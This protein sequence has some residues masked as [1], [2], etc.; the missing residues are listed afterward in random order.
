MWNSCPPLPPFFFPFEK[1]S[2]EPM[3]PFVITTS[4]HPSKS[5]NVSSAKA[6]IVALLQEYTNR[7]S[8]ELTDGKV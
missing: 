4:R 2:V 7:L 1:V 8:H 3:V 6:F 5:P